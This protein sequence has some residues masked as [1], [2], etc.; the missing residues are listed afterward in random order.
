MIRI[1][2]VGLGFMGQQ[3]FSIYQNMEQV[4]LVAVCDKDPE[5]VRDSVPAIAGNI[6][7]ATELELDGID[8]YT[9]FAQ[10]IEDAQLDCVD[11]CTPT[12][13]HPDMTVDAL[14]AGLHVI[15]EKPMALSVSECDRMIAAAEASSRMLFIA[16]CIRFWPEYVVLADMLADGRLGRVVSARFTR[17]S[18]TPAWSSGSWL[19]DAELSGGAVLDLHIHDVDFIL[20]LFG[21][22]Q[23]V[24]SRG[25]N[26]I[27]SGPAVDHVLTTYLYDGFAC[28][29]EGGWV[30]PADFP[31]ER[32]FQVLGE[33]G[34]LEL[35]PAKQPELQFYP[36][37]GEPHTPEFTPGTGYERELEYF[38]QCMTSGQA[39]TR[40]TPQAAREAVAMVMAERESIRTGQVVSLE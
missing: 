18:P 1:G 2:L 35:S 25:G 3:H 21:K 27:S 31:F 20:S 12:P 32:G 23:G 36:F 38:A 33:K 29:A 6:G 40:I 16:Q 37:D 15:C 30:F 22:P 17:H 39:P 26:L 19:L 7:D 5:R 9:D 24:L 10:M 13:L 28:N 4:E 34:F 11:I 14:Q 8:R